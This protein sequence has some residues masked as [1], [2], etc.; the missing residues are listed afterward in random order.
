M[1]SLDTFTK[2]LTL[3]VIQGSLVTESYI[4]DTSDVNQRFLISNPNVDTSTLKVFVKENKFSDFIEEY[5][6]NDDTMSLTDI[7]TRYFLQESADGNYEVLFGDGVL[8]K[9]L[10]SGNELTIRYITSAGR[11]SKWTYWPDDNV[12]KRC[13]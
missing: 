10:V 11:C 5:T 4:V 1:D 2:Y 13:S 12:G 9:N 7:S 6:L 8:G 3:E